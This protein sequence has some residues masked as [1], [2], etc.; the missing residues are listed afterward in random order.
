MILSDD[1]KRM[2]RVMRRLNWL[3]KDEIVEVKGKVACEVSAC[4]E[5]LVLLFKNNLR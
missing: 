1:L 2:K 3:N 4:D 5:I